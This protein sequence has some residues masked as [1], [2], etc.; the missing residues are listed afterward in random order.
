[1]AESRSD[2]LSHKPSLQLRRAARDISS[3]KKPRPQTMSE[4]AISLQIGSQVSQKIRP[5]VMAHVREQAS[6]INRR[7]LELLAE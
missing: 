3:D 5:Q 2:S 1:M 4:D 7:L 6:R